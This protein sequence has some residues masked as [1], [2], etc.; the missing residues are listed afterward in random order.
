MPT[1]TK[2]LGTKEVAAQVK[3]EPRY[4]RV[5]LRRIKG[6]APGD[7]YQWKPDDPFLKKL[8]GLIKAEEKKADTAKKA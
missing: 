4:L 7:R 3:V 5:L 1:E 2:M 6:K 8:P